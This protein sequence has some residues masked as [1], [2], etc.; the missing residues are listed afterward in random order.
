M[1]RGET[2]LLGL[3]LVGGL[4]LALVFGVFLKDGDEGGSLPEIGVERSTESTAL[5]DQAIRDRI[6][7][8]AVLEPEK[9]PVR[10]DATGRDGSPG[11]DSALRRDRE[12]AILGRII[13]EY[14]DPL[15]GATVRFGLD[16]MGMI[17]DTLKTR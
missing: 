8:P 9:V 4:G 10:P 15:P 12:G 5:S 7:D 6:E 1:K 3:I 11:T 17:F 13:S 16:P 2:V 14:G